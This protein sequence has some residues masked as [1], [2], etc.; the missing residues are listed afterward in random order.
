MS[1]I[2]ELKAERE[3][4]RAILKRETKPKSGVNQAELKALLEMLR[5][6]EKKIEQAT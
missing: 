1:T 4:I 5:N 3:T 6:V 2:E